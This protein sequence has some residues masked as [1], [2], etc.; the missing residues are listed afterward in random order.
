MGVDDAHVH[1]GRAFHALPMARRA[2]WL[3]HR[4]RSAST[5]LRV[6]VDVDLDQGLAGV[7]AMLAL[8]QRGPIGPQ[9]VAFAHQGVMVRPGMLDLLDQAVLAG[10][11]TLGGL[12]PVGVDGDPKGQLNA[13]FAIAERRGCTLDIHLHDRGDAGALTLDLIAERCRT[14]GLKGRVS[15]SHADCLRDLA[16]ARREQVLR[17][18]RDHDIAVRPAP[19]PVPAT[20]P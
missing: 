4:G 16:P 9:V 13:L 17:L 5:P 8:A 7:H 10:A 11:H 20:A 1:V 12:D 18:L 6:F 15:V 19:P 14:L 3:R 2:Q